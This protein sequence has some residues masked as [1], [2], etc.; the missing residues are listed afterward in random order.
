MVEDG[1]CGSCKNFR[2]ID[3]EKRGLT[4]SVN[5]LKYYGK[6]VVGICS[7]LQKRWGVGSPR[8]LMRDW[9]QDCDGWE[10]KEE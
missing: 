7:V 3:I 1:K 10:F 6:P 2:Y 8:C 4:G 9:D 5:P